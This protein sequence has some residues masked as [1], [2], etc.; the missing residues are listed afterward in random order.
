MLVGLDCGMLHWILEGRRY[1]V[2]TFAEQEFMSHHGRGSRLCPL[3]DTA[4]LP[5][6]V[7]DHIPSPTW[8]GAVSGDRNGLK[9]LEGLHLNVALV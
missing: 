2:Y 1:R 4:P 8:R 3:C 5:S 9:L 6:S 7:L